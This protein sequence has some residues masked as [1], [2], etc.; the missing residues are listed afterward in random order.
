MSFQAKTYLHTW[1]DQTVAMVTY[2]DRIFWCLLWNDL[3]FHWS[4]RS[5]WV[6]HFSAL[7]ER[8]RI[9][10]QSWNIFLYFLNCDWM[11]LKENMICCH[12]LLSWSAPYSELPIIPGSGTTGAPLGAQL[13]IQPPV[14][15]V[16]KSN[17]R[18]ELTSI[19]WLVGTHF[20]S[21]VSWNL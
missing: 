8:F 7:A 15:L 5:A 18:R 11:K 17:R 9:S 12:T 13:H 1:K 4:V 10:T 21:L 20:N 6:K 19:H 16:N 3:V 14:F 2:K